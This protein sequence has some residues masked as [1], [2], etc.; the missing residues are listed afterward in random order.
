MKQHIKSKQIIL[1]QREIDQTI[2]EIRM[3][4]RGE[5]GSTDNVIKRYVS[6]A[7]L[8]PKQQN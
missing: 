5:G 1:K 3:A 8:S 7:G 6:K 4:E 2:Q